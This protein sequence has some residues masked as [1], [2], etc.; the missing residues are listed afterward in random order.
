MGSQAG[1][2]EEAADDQAERRGWAFI[3]LTLP[4]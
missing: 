1:Q 4:S 3:H 2:A